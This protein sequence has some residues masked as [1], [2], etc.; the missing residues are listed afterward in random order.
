MERKEIYVLNEQDKKIV[1]LFNRLGMPK[2]L[3]KT[4]LYISQVG[5]ECYSEDIQWGTD[6]LQPDVS[7]AMQELCKRGWA[8]KSIQ[9]KK[10]MG[11]GRP[12]DIYKTTKDLRLSDIV[13]AFDQEKREEFENARKKISELQ[14]LL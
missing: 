8:E 7:I 12:R 2:H 14:K 3:A 1:Q 10:K 9:K 13:K 5:G 11:K 4:L 6:L